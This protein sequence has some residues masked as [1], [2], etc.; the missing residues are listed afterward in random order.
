M[1]KATE[2]KVLDAI[3]QLEKRLE[4]IEAGH[5]HED[6]HHIHDLLKSKV[7]GLGDA[8]AQYVRTYPLRSAAIAFLLGVLIASRRSGR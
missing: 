6:A 3:A 5:D 1:D 8:L 4:G 2:Q 7:D